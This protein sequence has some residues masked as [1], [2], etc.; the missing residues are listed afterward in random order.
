VLSDKSLF[1]NNKAEKVNRES[2]LTF[3]KE[4]ACETTVLDIFSKVSNGKVRVCC[5]VHFGYYDITLSP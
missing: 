3:S 2:A 1:E 5:G 4:H